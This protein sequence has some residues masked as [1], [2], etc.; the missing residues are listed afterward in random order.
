MKNFK[1]LKSFARDNIGSFE[2][3]KQNLKDVRETEKK[4]FSPINMKQL[5][6]L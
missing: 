1:Q 6:Q 5:Q 2:N 3:R 4:K